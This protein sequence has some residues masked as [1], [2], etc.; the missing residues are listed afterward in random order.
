MTLNWKGN[1]LIK[2][3]NGVVAWAINKTMAEAKK[4]AL[5]HHPQW[6]Y[7]SGVAEKSIRIKEMATPKRHVGL[8][9][10]VWTILNKS[11]Y[12]WYLEFNHGS[13]LRNAADVKYPLLSKLIKAGFKRSITG[14]KKVK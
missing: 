13:F 1:E 10:S 11:N 8:W 7:R 9:G 2:K 4:Y 5:N 3:K 12:V 14:V 6:Q